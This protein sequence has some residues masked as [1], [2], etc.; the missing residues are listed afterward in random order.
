MGLAPPEPSQHT[1]AKLLCWAPLTTESQAHL[2][3]DTNPKKG[4]RFFVV[5]TD[6][7]KS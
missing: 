2:M 5:C 7:N 4:K 1:E 3:K 6:G